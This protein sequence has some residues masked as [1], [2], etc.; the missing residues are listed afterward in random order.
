MTTSGQNDVLCVVKMCKFAN[1]KLR[2]TQFPPLLTG[3]TQ[4]KAQQTEAAQ[5]EHALKSEVAPIALD[6]ACSTT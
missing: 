2:K 1:S 5:A 3:Q 4:A 6:R